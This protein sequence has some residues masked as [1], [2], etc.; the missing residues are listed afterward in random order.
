MVQQNYT[1]FTRKNRDQATQDYTIRDIV[2]IT[3][4]QATQLDDKT[5]ADNFFHDSF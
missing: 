1:R 2:V 4:A 3:E 5:H